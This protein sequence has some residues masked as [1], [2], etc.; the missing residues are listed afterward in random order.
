MAQKAKLIDTSLCQGCKACQI[1]C[2]QWN[3]LESSAQLPKEPEE[4]L[5]QNPSELNYKTWCVIK[6]YETSSQDKIGWTFIHNSCRHCPD[7]FC[8]R[9]CPQTRPPAIE[10]HKATGAVIYYP[11]RCGNCCIECIK[12]C[13]FNIPRLELDESLRTLRRA[14]KCRLC[15]DRIEESEKNLLSERDRIPACVKACPTSALKFGIKSWIQKI[16][17]RR[18]EVLKN[19]GYNRAILYPGPDWNALWILKEPLDKF[20]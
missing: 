15:L 18:I 4:S 2:K 20:N 8:K 17:R 6:F 14:S 10:K 19:K 16:A 5:Y 7:P 9:G 3:F 11:E 1:A 13:P 12:A